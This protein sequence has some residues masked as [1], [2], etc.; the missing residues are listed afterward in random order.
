MA[1]IGSAD[2][3]TA[4][5]GL[6]PDG[7]TFGPKAKA[8]ITAAL[9]GINAQVP[10]SIDQSKLTASLAAAGTKI[11]ALSATTGALAD[12]LGAMRAQV[13][14][15]AAEAKIV[16]LQARAAS[17][18]KTLAAAGPN[19]NTLA[20]ESQLLNLTAAA[21]KAA[22]AA[23]TTGRAVNDVNIVSG[24]WFRTLTN[25]GGVGIPL[26]SGALGAMIPA[27]EESDSGI[28]KLAGHLVNVTSGWHLMTE[29]VIETA[30]IWIP[31][32]I[33]VTA[34]GL[35]AAPTVMAVTK[36][37]QNMNTAS[38]ATGLSFQ[39][40]ATSGA[41]VTQAVK[42]SVL[43]AF[44]IGLNVIKNSSGGLSGVLATLGQGF[45]VFV[46]KA[47]NAFGS[48]G[49]GGFMK[50][51]SADALA[52]T[53]S[54]ADLGDI[55]ATVMKAVPG[56][57]GIL[58]GFG[59]DMLGM[60]AD[61]TKAIEPVLAEFLKLHGAVLYGGLF[62]TAAAFGIS[63][64]I[65]A[66]IS[67]AGAV[68]NMAASVLGDENLISRGA[69]GVVVALEDMSVGPVIAGV[70]LLAGAIA[71]VVLYLKASK[72]AAQDFNSTIQSTLSGTP[73]VNLPQALAASLA[74]SNEKVAASSAAVT[75]ALAAQHGATGEVT[76][77]TG[78][79]NSVVKVV[80][81]GLLAA[82]SANATYNAGQ[83]LLSQQSK[84]LNLN[85]GAI[86]ATTGTTLPQALALASGAQVTSNQ[87]LASGGDNWA[88]ISTMVAGYVSQLKVMT[89]GVGALNQALNALNVT[90][91]AQVADAQKVAQA[92][93]SFI[94]IVTG[95]DSAFVT[96]EQGQQTLSDAMAGGS[97]AGTTLSV[98]VGKLTEKYPLL[99]TALN[100][101]TTSALAARGAFDQQVTAAT[102]LYGNLQ[103]MAVVSGSTSQAQDALAKSGK[104]LV[105]QLLPMAA[106]SKTATAEVFALAQI[107]GYGGTDSFQS[108]AKWVGNTKGAEGD[109]N[110]QT[111]ILTLSSANLTQASKNLT[112]AMT[113]M[114]NNGEAAAIAKGLNLQQIQD[115]LAA[116]VENANGKVTAA[117]LTL[118]GQYYQAL[119]KSGD[120]TDTAK[121]KVDAFL[122]KLGA[123][124]GVVDTVNT[125]LAKLPT[126]VT[127]NVATNVSGSGTVKALEGIA[128]PGSTISQNL[129]GEITF[130]KAGGT[131]TGHG[132]SGQDSKLIMAAPGELIIPTSHAALFGDAA[133]RA[134]VP[135]FAAGGAVGT[136][137]HVAA[138]LGQLVPLAAN[139]DTS[140]SGAAVAAFA[141]AMIAAQAQMGQVSLAG[142]S[143][144]SALAALESAAAKH[145]WTG[146]Q[147]LALND[148]ELREAGYSLTATN[149]SSG[150]YGMAQFI[151]GPGEY[152]LYGGNSATAA[153]QAVAMT[154]YIA[155]RYH[156]PVAADLHEKIFGWYN[157][158]GTVGMANG[159]VISEP[160][161]GVGRSGR[162][163]TF[164][165][166]G[167]EY[168][169][170]ADQV[171]P[172][173]PGMPP[174]TQYQGQTLIQLLQVMVKQ[175]QQ[176]P[177]NVAQALNSANATGVRRGY[178]ATAG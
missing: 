110:T 120:S 137:G 95:G 14:T 154:N 175:G 74:Q 1:G 59:N 25:I 76:E 101:T 37:L 178:F 19:A 65:P 136:A 57:A 32:T 2:L 153:G 104:D 70:G 107:A 69:G 150:A 50:Q 5:V 86:A 68:S 53:Q 160:V 140:F 171:T 142:V 135:G 128:A 15:T 42:P 157:R 102:T 93:S 159:G 126:Q 100:G 41:S 39:S 127:V 151:D 33:A 66:A 146:V 40:L 60:G 35:A 92:Y 172:A 13:D 90:Q 49:S 44:G 67:V 176:A 72:S 129:L 27:L 147:W 170:P 155:A 131:V 158:G 62:G 108:L 56:Y 77:D 96:F 114:V 34:F 55:F 138:E 99:G 8:Q 123:T 177:Y 83:Q 85:L 18:Q 84:N 89:P 109:L 134:S 87:L 43:E 173:S 3:A 10:L 30:A 88:V 156:D 45:D 28:V 166:N 111:T 82:A 124:P 113:T 94:G 122:L 75:T 152:A 162:N 80:P 12:R 17:L 79:M 145:G 31:A 174:M 61:V 52:L 48:G 29:A 46:A 148:I 112:A 47:A 115:N 51:G 63:K 64:L 103:D 4:W 11:T 78:K 132:P 54:F 143:N 36:Q 169:T 116:S 81:A 26:F 58:L 91:S 21:D 118:A 106:G 161:F 6:A 97:A 16:A 38:T 98:T 24:N 139:S 149:P 164:G 144:A 163:Y 71:A 119:V 121:G 141:K 105:A 23:Q 133:R 9:K 117:G 167:S 73:A 7:S 125:A 168:V 130:S 165:E 22:A 20:L